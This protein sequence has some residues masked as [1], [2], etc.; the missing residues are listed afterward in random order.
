MSLLL[1]PYVKALTPCNRDVQRPQ[2]K[3]VMHKQQFAVIGLGSFGTTIAIELARLGHEVLGVDANARRVDELAEVLTHSVVADATDERALEELNLPAYDAAVVA[4]GENVEASILCTMQLKT[5]GVK[6]VWVKALTNRHHQI[7]AKIGADRIVHPE[8]DVGVRV[9]QALNYPMVN[10]YISLGDE[11]FV[12]EIIASLKL[13]NRRI[14][15]LLRATKADV[16]VLLVKRAADV[17][18]HPQA[19]Y[20]LVEGDRVVF[21]GELTELR[22]LARAV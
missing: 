12:V 22:K 14:D 9:A 17:F 1:C 11:R 2:I 20:L 6:Q 7:L 4:I 19:D 5:L 8:H 21:E 3:A 15:D 10:N 18:L 13:Q 16:A